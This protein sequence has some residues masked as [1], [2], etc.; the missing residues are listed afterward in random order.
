MQKVSY[1]DFDTFQL[2]H[3]L[4]ERRQGEWVTAIF[5]A[6]DAQEKAVYQEQDQTPNDHGDLLSLGVSHAW[7]L[8]SQ[9]DGAEREHTIYHTWVS[10]VNMVV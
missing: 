8:D 3:L 2:L 4:H 7:D 10:W 5:D 9:R 6:E 1:L